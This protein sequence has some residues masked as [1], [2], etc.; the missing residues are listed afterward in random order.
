MEDTTRKL[1]RNA[2]AGINRWYCSHYNGVATA[3][4]E[5]LS[6]R[7]YCVHCEKANPPYEEEPSWM[8]DEEQ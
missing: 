8:K 1:C 7:G 5:T 2:F 3:G 4:T 6:E